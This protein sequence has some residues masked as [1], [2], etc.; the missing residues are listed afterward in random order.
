MVT[1]ARRAISTS[2]WPTPTVSTRTTSRPAASN[3]TVMSVVVR[4]SPPILA[5]VNQPL[6]FTR[7]LADG[8]QL[9]VTIEL[10]D[11]VVLDEAVA[12]MDLDRLIANSNRHFGRE[13][14]GHRRLFG[15]PFALVLHVGRPVNEKA[16]R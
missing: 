16:R 8:A 3:K 2:S 6:D 7:A 1:S 10:L 15:D 5:R 9:D 4:A 11:R 13:E 14:L 12:A